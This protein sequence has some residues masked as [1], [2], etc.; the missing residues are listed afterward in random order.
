MDARLQ[1]RVQRYGWD[2]ASEVYDRAW[3]QPLEPAQNALLEMAALQPGD[4]VL[5]VACGSGLVTVR[6][7]EAVGPSGRVVATDLSEGMLERAREALAPALAD[8]VTFER[9]DAEAL[10]LHDEDFDV[11]IASL[12]LMY[13]PNPDAALREMARVLRPGGRVVASVW[14]ERSACGWA[15]VFPIVDARVRTAVCPLF[16]QLGT[17]EAL[18][19]AMARA[20]LDRLAERRIRTTLHFPTAEAAL[21]A[22]FV[23]GPVAMAYSRFEAE[24]R[25]AVQR[26]YLESIEPFHTADG[27]RIPGEFVVV[28]GRRATP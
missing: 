16:F 7:A 19:D 14:G 5:E 18:R 20:G 3:S 26:E 13:V 23:G 25:E 4:E 10:G 6:A 11:A 15:E 24:I 17:G 1:L 21:E 27:Y 2:R 22:A 8:R 9:R 12:G 28:S